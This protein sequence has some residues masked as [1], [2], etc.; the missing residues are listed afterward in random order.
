MTYR[1]H[2]ECVKIH[3]LEER[4]HKHARPNA[5]T[6]TRS[7]TNSRSVRAQ[8][9]E[10]LSWNRERAHSSFDESNCHYYR[11]EVYSFIL[12]AEIIFTY[13]YDVVVN[14]CGQIHAYSIHILLFCMC[15]SE[16][17]YRYFFQL[18]PCSML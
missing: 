17:T 15:D 1:M 9:V 18:I 16:S 8:R 2:R 6:N 13:I 4:L 14:V 12:Y 10:I 11:R 5:N 7:H 3:M